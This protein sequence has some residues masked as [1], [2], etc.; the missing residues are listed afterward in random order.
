MTPCFQGRPNSRGVPKSPTGLLSSAGA[1]GFPTRAGWPAGP[2]ASSGQQ[3]PVGAGVRLSE[4]EPMLLRRPA[5]LPGGAVSATAAWS[6]AAPAPP[7]P[8]GSAVAPQRLDVGEGRWSLPRSGF[9]RPRTGPAGVGPRCLAPASV[10]ARS[11]PGG[12]QPLS[13]GL[14]PERG[15]PGISCRAGRISPILGAF[16]PTAVPQG[17]LRLLIIRSGHLSSSS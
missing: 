11:A 15:V 4:A 3:A 6:G 5:R 1:R 7:S 17:R 14:G 10:Q 16:Q 13:G 12:L 2:R 8:P 9:L